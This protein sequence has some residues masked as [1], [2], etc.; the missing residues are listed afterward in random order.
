MTNLEI[1][2]GIKTQLQ[3]MTFLLSV[4]RVEEANKCL[5]KSFNM[6]EAL[7]VFASDEYSTV[8]TEA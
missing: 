5:Q 7:K 6:L 8:K 1:I 4:D 2:E 3:L